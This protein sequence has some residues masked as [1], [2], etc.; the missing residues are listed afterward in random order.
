MS[1]TY[2]ILGYADDLGGPVVLYESDSYTQCEQW[3]DD[4]TRWGDWG[5]YDCLVLYEIAPHQSATTIHLHDTHTI[6]W[7]VNGSWL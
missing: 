1:D 4:Y 2:A 5:G 7:H 3:K 6:A